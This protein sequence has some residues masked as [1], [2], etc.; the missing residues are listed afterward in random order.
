ML[1][2]AQDNSLKLFFQ[3]FGWVCD[4]RRTQANVRPDTPR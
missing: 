4:V 1:D 3:A 2:W